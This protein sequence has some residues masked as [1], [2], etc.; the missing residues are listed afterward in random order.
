MQ[1]EIINGKKI[2]TNNRKIEEIMGLWGEIMPLHLTG[3][4]YAVYFNFESNH[5]GDYDLLI[6][7]K[8]ATMEDSISLVANKYMC[9]PVEDNNIE[10]V[11][12]AWQAIWSNPEIET[13]RAYLTDFEK[14]AQDGSITIYLSIQ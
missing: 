8:T 4:L 6:G 12:K 11:G 14:Y 2:R 10:N 7:T 9:I 13:K 5:L 1:I 3:D